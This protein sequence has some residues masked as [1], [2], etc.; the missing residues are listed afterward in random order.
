MGFKSGVYSVIHASADADFANYM[1]YE[2]YA[3]A[4]ATPTINGVVVS[5]GA[6]S[7]LPI[8][9]KAISSTANVYVLGDKIDVTNGSPT[10]SNYPEPV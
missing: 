6:S 4:A 3:S 2:I 10:L 7:T 1:Y 8:I 5:M 9:L